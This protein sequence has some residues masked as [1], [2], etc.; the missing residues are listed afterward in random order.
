MKIAVVGAGISGLVAADALCDHHQVTVFE[1][2]DYVGGHTDTHTVSIDGQPW[3]VDTGFIVF[4]EDH[5]PTLTNLFRRLG[6]DWIDSDMSFSVSNRESGLEYNTASIGRLFCQP[7]NLLR[8]SFY[9]MVLDIRRF[10]KTA[11][12][13]LN[14][15]SEIS[16][17]DYLQQGGYGALFIHDHIVPMTSALWSCNADMALQY[18]ARYLLQFMHNH[19]ML[20]LSSRPVWKTVRGGSR[21]Y[22][23]RLLETQR[24]EAHTDAEVMAIS[25]T[26]SS[27]RLMVNGQP[28]QF[29]A[30]I[31]A[32]HG[33]QVLPM[34][35][36]PGLIEQ[37]VF[38]GISTQYNRMTLHT[39]SS[40]MPQRKSA[41][42]SWNVVLDGRSQRECTVSYYMNLLQSLD[43]P[44]PLIVSLNQE[45]RIDPDHILLS[46]DYHHPVYNEQTV[47][48]A[49]RVSSCQGN[50]RTW[51]C[52]AWL[53]WGFHEDGARSGLDAAQLL[54]HSLG[55]HA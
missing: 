40:V 44:E 7:S 17:G 51:Y 43:C 53:G 31:M 25:R 30:L 34:L 9:R 19:Q 16:L 55:Q 11:S 49:S 35:E 52:G 42:A 4:N 24:F 28:H 14:K 38:S 5:Y 18:P 45:D 47:S 29:D 20:Q 50:L 6:V 54:D 12:E 36:Q 37:S 27:V 2:N 13:L 26:E 1:K 21:T 46:R 33:D 23:D 22:I 10:Y 8:P 3:T 41:W 48:A 15:P 39:D 32:C